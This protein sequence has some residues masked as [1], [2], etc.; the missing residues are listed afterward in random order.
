MRALLFLLALICAAQALNSCVL[1][2]NVFHEIEGLILVVAATV[3]LAG[4]G[5]IHAI[6]ALAPPNPAPAPP[7]HVDHPGPAPTR[8]PAIPPLP[9]KFWL[10]FA[11]VL[12]TAWA[13]GLASLYFRGLVS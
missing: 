2:K 11:V 4:G 5:I 12:G 8:P 7:E 9:R 10:W 3:C 1:S 6:Q 13:I